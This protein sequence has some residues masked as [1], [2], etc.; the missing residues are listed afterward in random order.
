LRSKFSPHTLFFSFMIIRTVHKGSPSI[1]VSYSRKF[2]R[3]RSLI[4]LFLRIGR[5]L[6]KLDPRKK[7][8]CTNYIKLARSRASAKIKPRARTLQTGHLRKLDTTKISL[9]T[10]TGYV[11]HECN[12][13]HLC[14]HKTVCYKWLGGGGM[15]SASTCLSAMINAVSRIVCTGTGTQDLLL[16]A[17]R[18]LY[19]RYRGYY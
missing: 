9:Y 19:Y 15:G 14:Y 5:Y 3:S 10:V 16:G 1:L 4:S 7:H 18:Q 11:N 13:K 17:Y 6:R 2:S 12:E 8:D